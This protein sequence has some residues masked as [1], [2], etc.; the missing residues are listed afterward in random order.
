M[1]AVLVGAAVYLTHLGKQTVKAIKQ[2]FIEEDFDIMAPFLSIPYFYLINDIIFATINS[3][4]ESLHENENKMLIV[5]LYPFFVAIG[6]LI[7]RIKKAKSDSENKP[8]E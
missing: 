4:F 6:D 3:G 7:S 5:L 8:N 1:S 2:I